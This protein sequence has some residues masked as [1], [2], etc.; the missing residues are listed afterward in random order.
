MDNSWLH[1]IIWVML[2]ILTFT[3]DMYDY[4]KMKIGW[5]LVT[6]VIEQRILMLHFEVDYDKMC[7]W[8]KESQ[9]FLSMFQLNQIL[10][11]LSISLCAVSW[12]V[13]KT[14]SDEKCSLLI[15]TCW[16]WFRSLRLSQAWRIMIIISRAEKKTKEQEK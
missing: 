16:K 14:S 3:N 7:Q 11:S 9:I 6:N 10:F 12:K 15:W 4:N 5:K 2:C 8:L 13:I 1:P